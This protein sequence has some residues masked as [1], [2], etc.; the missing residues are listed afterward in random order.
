MIQVT[1]ETIHVMNNCG[2]YLAFAM[3]LAGVLWG[4][5]E[6]ARGNGYN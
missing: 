4:R 3:P 6:R 5:F 2:F 1:P